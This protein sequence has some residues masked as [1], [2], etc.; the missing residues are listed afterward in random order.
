MKARVLHYYTLTAVILTLLLLI[1]LSILEVFPIS[2]GN[3]YL[4]T[5][6]QANLQLIR[7]E[8]IVRSV[9]FLQYRPTTNHA[10]AISDLQILL[11]QFEEVQNGLLHGDALMGIPANPPS[12]VQEALANTDS[13][14]QQ[15]VAATKVVLTHPDATIDPLQVNIILMHDRTYITNMAETIRAI[16]QY[17]DAQTQQLII[18]RIVFISAVVVL[19]ILKYLLFTL[20]TV[21]KMVQTEKQASLLPS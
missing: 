13:D 7:A 12:S 18:A 19:V 6:R 21:R 10:Q 17:N 8:F 20:P 2:S 1:S 15:I 16:E 5:D 11:P 14:Y 3:N 9:L 4:V